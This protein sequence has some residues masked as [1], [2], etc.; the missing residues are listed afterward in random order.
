[1]ADQRRITVTIDRLVLR[2]AAAQRPELFRRA[3]TSSLTA[4]LEQRGLPALQSSKDAPKLSLKVK[5]STAAA[6]LPMIRI[7]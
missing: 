1:M 4:A 7:G 3:L 5:P 2:G 6:Q